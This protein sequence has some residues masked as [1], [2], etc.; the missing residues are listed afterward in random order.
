MNIVSTHIMNYYTCTKCG[1]QTVI[2]SA[3]DKIEG[4]SCTCGTDTVTLVKGK[5]T[6]NKPAPQNVV[7]APVA[8]VE[9]KD[10]RPKAPEVF[11][12]QQTVGSVK[13]K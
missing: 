11:N 13:G 8:K 7:E 5:Q 2:M 10:N 9:L 12:P 3:A 4:A 1:A 6:I